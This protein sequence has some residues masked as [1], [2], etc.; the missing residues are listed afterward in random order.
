MVRGQAADSGGAER[1]G[2]RLFSPACDRGGLSTISG[3]RSEG[4]LSTHPEWADASPHRP[5]PR[6]RPELRRPS[7]ECSRRVRVPSAGRRSA[8][9]VSRR[10]GERG[11]RR[12]RRP[13][14][15]VQGVCTPTSRRAVLQPRDST[16]AARRSAAGVSAPAS[17]SRIQPPPSAG[18]ENARGR[19]PPVAVARAGVDAVRGRSSGRAPRASLASGRDELV[20][21]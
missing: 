20:A 8:P 13:A 6:T 19:R 18:A 15:P 21:R 9:P 4:A 3:N 2:I 1:S 11:C 17:R 12:A 10:Q 7:C 14:L 5:S 16:R